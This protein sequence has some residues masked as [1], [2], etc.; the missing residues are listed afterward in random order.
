[1][2][3]P[4]AARAPRRRPDVFP[5]IPRR[6][7]PALRNPRQYPPPRQKRRSPELRGHR[8]ADRPKISPDP[9]KQISTD[10]WN[11]APWD[12]LLRLPSGRERRYSSAT[13]P[14]APR[15]FPSAGPYPP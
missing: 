7:A 5:P 9:R 6:R 4:E 2:G 8:T 14:S 13:A 3:P 12:L 11:P 1:G 10:P 15:Q